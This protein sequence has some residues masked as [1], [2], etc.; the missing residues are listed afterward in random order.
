MKGFVYIL[1]N[2]AMPGIVKIGYTAG[3]VEQRMEQL[4][5]TGVPIPF[6]L[7]ACFAV[8][9]AQQC[10]AKVHDVLRDVRV[11]DSREFFSLS[12]I[13]AIQKV[14]DVVTGFLCHKNLM[15]VPVEEV[16]VSSEAE[17][18]LGRVELLTNEEQDILV[19]LAI[20]YRYGTDS[21]SLDKSWFKDNELYITN[22]L[23]RLK[24]KSLVSERR[25]RGDEASM[26]SISSKG[27]NYLFKI[28]VFQENEN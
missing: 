26:W 4:N 15:N 22:L 24:E 10:E 2:K 6:E 3:S 23:Y 18:E 17:R 14:S 25:N 13:E 7:L 20:K 1:Q 16:S 12:L 21:Y 5:T 9:H 19:E 8:S 11:N 27:I 28:G